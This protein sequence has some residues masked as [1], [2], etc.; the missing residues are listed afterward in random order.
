MTWGGLEICL[1][2]RLQLTSQLLAL[3]FIYLCSHFVGV[4]HPH[5]ICFPKKYDK[6]KAR[7]DTLE[8]WYRRKIVWGRPK[9]NNY[10]NILAARLLSSIGG[11]D[12][13]ALDPETEAIEGNCYIPCRLVTIFRWLLDDMAREDCVVQT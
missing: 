10:M 12:C 11:G 5:K 9:L 4:K 8:W 13:L 1:Y 7:K 3:H 2:L 6:D